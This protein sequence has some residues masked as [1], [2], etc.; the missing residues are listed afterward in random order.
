MSF[1]TINSKNIYHGR[2][3]DIRQDEIRLPNGKPSQVDVVVHGGA[4]VLLPFDS[5]GRI[6]FV[7][8]Y[9]HAAGVNLLELPAG[10]LES[11]ESP[12][13]SALREIREEIGMAAGRI[14]KIGEIYLAPGYS[15]EYSYV[16]LAT[17]LKPDP[18][19]GDED[20]FISVERMTLDEV[21][22]LIEAGKIHDAKTLAGIMLARPYLTST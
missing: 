14:Q 22:A 4:V 9:R 2:V 7:R 12:E 13:H 5:E 18:L 11:G 19:P 20:E 6:W 1:E 15:S 17:D 3:F 10:T 21:F 8:Q 16:Y